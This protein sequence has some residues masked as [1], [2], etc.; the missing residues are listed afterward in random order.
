MNCCLCDAGVPAVQTT[1]VPVVQF[2]QFRFPR[3]KRKRTQ[4]KWAKRQEN[5][6]FKD[7]SYLA[8][9]IETINEFSKAH[10]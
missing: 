1:R 9:D 4:K 5:W 6:R 10:R 7:V 8:V 2:E 3:S